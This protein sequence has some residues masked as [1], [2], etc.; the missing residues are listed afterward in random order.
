M[1]ATATGRTVGNL[2]YICKRIEHR[3]E[4]LMG[5][6]SV[7]DLRKCHLFAVANRVVFLCG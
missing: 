1:T 6:E 4:M 3:I 5:V 7:G 2:L